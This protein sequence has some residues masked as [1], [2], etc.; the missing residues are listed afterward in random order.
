MQ[1]TKYG[2]IK[3]GVADKK[4]KA[5]LVR[6]CGA[7]VYVN[8]LLDH[9]WL[10]N[11]NGWW[12]VRKCWFPFEHSIY[13]RFNIYHDANMEIG[14]R[15]CRELLGIARKQK[16]KFRWFTMQLW[17]EQYMAMEFELGGSLS[18]IRIIGSMGPPHLDSIYKQRIKEKDSDLLKEN[19]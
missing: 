14:W 12:R 4:H 9:K 16:K 18:P 13:R 10:V 19:K 17:I 5:R 11:K 7:Q 3:G 15:R 2:I 1:I 8:D 6:N